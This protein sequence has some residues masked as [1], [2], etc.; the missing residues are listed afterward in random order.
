M[1]RYKRVRNAIE[2]ARDRRWHQKH[3][4]RVVRPEPDDDP[5]EIERR[6]AAIRREKMLLRAVGKEGTCSPRA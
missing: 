6:T 4:V 2:R 3:Y 1:K 5:A